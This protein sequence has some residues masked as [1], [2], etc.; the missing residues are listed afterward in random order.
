MIAPLSLT[1]LLVDDDEATGREYKTALENIDMG[2]RHLPNNE[3]AIK[4]LDD[5]AQLSLPLHILM[6]DI[7]RPNGP[8]GL[9]FIEHIRKANYTRTVGGG[10]RLR[11]LPLVVISDHVSVYKEHVKNID[12]AIRRSAQQRD[13]TEEVW[14][15][16]ART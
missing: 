5:M 9:K 12:A 14:R 1:A 4:A 15:S 8:D 10:L 13:H 11:Y 6:T 2:L 16:H 7:M 3:E